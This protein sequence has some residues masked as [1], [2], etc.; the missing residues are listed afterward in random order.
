MCIVFYLISAYRVDCSLYQ[1]YLV[2]DCLVYSYIIH[3]TGHLNA[4]LH[5]PILPSHPG[6]T[7]AETNCNLYIFSH[8]AESSLLY[9]ITTIECNF[10]KLA[11]LI[12]QLSDRQGEIML[13]LGLANNQ[14]I[15][16][17]IYHRI[18]DVFIHWWLVQH[19]GITNPNLRGLATISQ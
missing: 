3:N 14:N 7:L 18:T 12:A 19:G 15:V 8:E 1:P 9:S 13:H 16:T 6:W 11:N 2:S 5:C 4:Q 10:G 17:I